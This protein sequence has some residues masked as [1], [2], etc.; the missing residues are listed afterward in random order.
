MLRVFSTERYRGGIQAFHDPLYQEF[1]NNLY[2]VPIVPKHLWESMS[3]EDITVGVNENPIGS[4]AY[5]YLTNSE[6]RKCGCAMKNGGAM[7][8][9]APCSKYIVDILTSSN[10]IAL[11]MVLKGSSI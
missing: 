8:F 9:S 2:N 1:E 5:K 10:N 6:D 11:G 7:V 4:G 3:E